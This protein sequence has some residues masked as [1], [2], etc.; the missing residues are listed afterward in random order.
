[1]MNEAR[2]S[3]ERKGN[4]TPLFIISIWLFSSSSDIQ[5]SSFILFVIRDESFQPA[6]V[7]FDQIKISPNIFA[8]FATCLLE[9]M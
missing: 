2:T 6:F 8:A 1:M 3:E 7:E 4:R 9:K 5:H